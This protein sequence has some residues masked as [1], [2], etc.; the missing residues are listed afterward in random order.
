MFQPFKQIL[1]ASTQDFLLK[2]SASDTDTL[3][4][5]FTNAHFLLYSKHNILGDL[6]D[7]NFVRMKKK[8]NRNTII[9]KIYG[10]K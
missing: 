2:W 10:T 7:E 4:T 8:I 1:P 6:K 3:F 9:L 5:Y